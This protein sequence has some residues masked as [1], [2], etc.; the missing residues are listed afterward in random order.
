MAAFS[1]RIRCLVPVVIGSLCLLQGAA[2][3]M[4]RDPLAEILGMGL[5]LCLPVCIY[6]RMSP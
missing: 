4:D 6:Y 1:T 3:A 2:P 5:W